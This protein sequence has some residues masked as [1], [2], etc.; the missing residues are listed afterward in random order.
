MQIPSDLAR[1]LRDCYP[2]ADNWLAR[3]PQQL[4]HC[5]KQ[6]QLELLGWAEQL[7]YHPV[8]WVR[9]HDGSQAILKLLPPGP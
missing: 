4:E 5:L 9:Q 8:L 6:W 3:W 1:H 7:S 2:Q